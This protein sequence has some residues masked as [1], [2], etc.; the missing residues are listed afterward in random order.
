[1]ANR[2]PK[3]YAVESVSGTEYDTSRTVTVVST[4]DR[5]NGKD[6]VKY[7]LSIIMVNE[8]D[9]W[10]VDPQSLQTYEAADT[11]DPSITETPSPTE[12]PAIYPDTVLYYNPSGG[13]YYHLDQNCKRINERY[14]PLQGHFKYS[15]LTNDKYS[16]LKPCA[17]CGAP[18]A[19]Q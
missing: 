13:E 11:P 10:Y 18:S 7:R 4:M 17:I 2:T 15:E 5:N 3:D 6:P 9:E 1:M 16:K 14:L 8:G 12:T 19:G